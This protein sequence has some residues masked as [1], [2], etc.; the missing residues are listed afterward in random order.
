MSWTKTPPTEPG[1]YWRKRVGGDGWIIRVVEVARWGV[2]GQYLR[3]VGTEYR[4]TGEIEEK[5]GVRWWPEPIP[6]PPT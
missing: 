5:T 4:N 3:V 6:Q 1:W 2:S